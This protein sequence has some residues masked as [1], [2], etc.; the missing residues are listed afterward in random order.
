MQMRAYGEECRT[1]EIE[2]AVETGMFETLKQPSVTLFEIYLAA[3]IFQ[4]ADYLPVFHPVSQRSDCGLQK[5]CLM[6]LHSSLPERY[7]PSHGHRKQ[8][9]VKSKSLTNFPS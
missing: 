3:L 8:T 5:E 4:R 2:G 1:K 7:N 9:S 6:G